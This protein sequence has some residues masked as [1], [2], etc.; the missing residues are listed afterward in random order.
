MQKTTSEPV[1]P[2][3]KRRRPESSNCGKCFHRVCP[4]GEKTIRK[5]ISSA[6]LRETANGLVG[7]SYKKF[8]AMI[9]Y[10]LER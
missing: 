7:G 3:T 5:L 9:S 2:G 10:G 6:V 4:D 1:S 8:F